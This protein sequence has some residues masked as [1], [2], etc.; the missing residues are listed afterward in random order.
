MKSKISIVILFF[1]TIIWGSAFVFQDIASEHVSSF[2]FNFL[3]F[4]FASIVLLPIAIISN[5]KD[6]K[7]G[8]NNSIKDL[9]LG[10]IVCGGFLCLASIL[11]QRGI[12][13][14]S[15]GKS[16]FIT[17]SYILFIPLISLIFKKRYSYHVY[18][19]V[20]IAVVGLYLLCIKGEFRLEIGDIYLIG[21]ALCFALQIIS[22]EYFAKR[23]NCICLSLGQSIVSCIVCLFFMIFIDKPTIQQIIPSLW[24]IL[25][26]AIFS[27]SIGYTLQ[28]AAQK[29]VN[30]TIASL[31]MSLESVFSVIFGAIILS[32]F[33]QIREIIGSIIMF[34]AIIFSQLPAEWFSFKKRKTKNTN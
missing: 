12:E 5:I 34:I 33:L 32:Q 21:C 11:Q 19:S 25:Y 4:F 17:A 13:T 23:V 9:V 30:P 18:L 8:I 2:T 6:K 27:T 16:G 26:I 28:I 7:K 10:S 22:I 1:V 20:L 3:R 14:T 31:I 24:P 29:N 15:V